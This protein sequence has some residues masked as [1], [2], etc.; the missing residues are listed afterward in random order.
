MSIEEEGEFVNIIKQ[1]NDYSHAER[2][3]IIMCEYSI[4]MYVFVVVIINPDS[5][6]IPS[7]ISITII[8]NI[9]CEI[10]NGIKLPEFIF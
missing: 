9:L 2:S 6:F 8:K 4:N 1:R 10:F 7:A 3:S 5:S